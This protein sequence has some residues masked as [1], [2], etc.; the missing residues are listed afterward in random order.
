MDFIKEAVEVANK[1]FNGDFKAI[2]YGSNDK[3]EVVTMVNDDLE[4]FGDGFE[5]PRYLHNKATDQKFLAEVL[6]GIE[7][8]KGFEDLDFSS[9][10]YRSL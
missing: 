7:N 5:Y 10:S 8:I 4:K 2:N 1:T 3:F 6:L 9:L